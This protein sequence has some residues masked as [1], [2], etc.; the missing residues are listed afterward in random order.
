M[1]GITSQ[2]NLPIFLNAVC[3]LFCKGLLIKSHLARMLLSWLKSCRYH[4][5][6]SQTEGLRSAL[7][8]ENA[9]K[10]KQSL[11]PHYS[12]AALA[13]DWG[14]SAAFVSNILTGKKF[15][16]M[17]RLPKL[18]SLLELDLNEKK[19]LLRLL[20]IEHQS[21]DPL[22]KPLAEIAQNGE[23]KF[24]TIR[25]TVMKAY[26]GVL[27][28]WSHLAILESLSTD[29]ANRG[30]QGIADLLSL[31]S[32]RIEKSLEL[33]AQNGLI[34]SSKNF[35][36]KNDHHIYFSSGRSRAEIR[37]FHSIMIEKAKI[38]M[39]TKIQDID[40]QRRLING[41]TLAFNPEN[42]EKVKAKLQELMS[43]VSLEGSEGICTEVYQLNL[44]FFPLSKTK[45]S[46]L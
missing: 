26:T 36:K 23:N 43:E 15:I 38:E 1:K 4:F 33:L 37:N 14:V 30:V 45:K 2:V 42:L 8:V 40:F 29:S 39:E 32:Q 21:Q 24:N 13:R 7:L 22:L 6:M 28:H 10:R 3:G 35:W 27:S 18:M 46:K 19:E 41:Y 9:F 11:V 31:P 34:I 20:S 16:P 12:R 5:Y 17:D 44:Q 25:K